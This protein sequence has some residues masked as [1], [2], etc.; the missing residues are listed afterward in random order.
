MKV[1]VLGSREHPAVIMIP[2]MFCTSEMPKVIGRY[3]EQDY[4]VILPT[5]D[6]HHESCPKYHSKE[7]DAREIIDW[8]KQQQI[9]EIALLQGTSMGAEVALE[10]AR[11]LDIPVRHYLYDGGPFFHFPRFFRAI[12]ARK[13]QMIVNLA[14][15]KETTEEAEEAILRNPLVRKL[16]G[17]NLDDYRGLL[18]SFA[19]IGRWISKDSIRRI[20][21]T[22]YRCIL[23]ELSEEML[24]RTTFL[25]SEKEPARKSEKRLKR[26]YPNA[27]FYVAKGFGHCGFQISDPTGYVRYIRQLIEQT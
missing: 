3:L 19:E 17:S 13:F 9:Q 2:G 24:A 4:Y 6:G 12:M 10:V 11:Q 20:A 23:P 5:L 15:S 27:R 7:Q 25:F 1:D 21:D 16:G 14:A 8:L 18:S 22:C 26:K